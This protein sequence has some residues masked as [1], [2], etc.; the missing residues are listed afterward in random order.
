VTGLDRRGFVKLGAGGAFFLGLPLA[1]GEERALLAKD[2]LQ[3]A[4]APQPSAPVDFAQFRAEMKKRNQPGVI[5][6]LQTPAQ[7]AGQ[8]KEDAKRKEVFVPNQGS[9]N[10]L[11]SAIHTSLFSCGDSELPLLLVQ[12]VFVAA[13]VESVRK[14]FP[15]LPADT[16]MALVGVDGKVLASLPADADLG[17]KFADRAAD[18]LYG[19]DG[20]RL[21]DRIKA[22]R[23]ALG[24]AAA[25]QLDAAVV[26]LDD[27][28]F[29]RRQAASETL[30]KLFAKVPASLAQAHRA[31]PSLEVR[32]RID[33]LFR[34]KLHEEN[35]A[36]LFQ[37]SLTP[38]VAAAVNFD[39][40]IKCGQG[41]LLPH[42]HTFVQLWCE[43]AAA[44]A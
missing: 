29:A 17:K 42:A 38:Y 20:A 13:P 23:T 2:A 6:L 34:K 44:Q 28:E 25:K 7:P 10:P 27:D 37:R 1:R 8:G 3:R 22:E 26:D 39:I 11:A 35:T 36:A 9:V 15:S 14:E 30:T 24:D 32:R 19:K 31:A 43:A 12:A 21:A 4:V 5:V 33:S 18:L 41:A 16:G 40:R